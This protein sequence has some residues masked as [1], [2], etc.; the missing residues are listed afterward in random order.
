MPLFCFVSRLEAEKNKAH[1]ARGPHGPCRGHPVEILFV[2]V[3]LIV[4]QTLFSSAALFSVSC[5]NSTDLPYLFC[6]NKWI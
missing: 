1:V 4:F 6:N 5:C 3:S 2:V